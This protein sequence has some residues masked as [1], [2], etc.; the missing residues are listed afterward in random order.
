MILVAFGF[1]SCKQQKVDYL[2]PLHEES[3]GLTCCA[4]LAAWQ[5]AQL[6]S[7]IPNDR[8]IMRR[9]KQGNRHGEHF[10]RPPCCI[11][12]LIRHSKSPM[13]VSYG[14]GELN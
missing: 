11:L 2:L 10:Q 7:P 13:G 9:T 5:A 1:K 4:A 14:T 3:T 8:L 12:G 6:I